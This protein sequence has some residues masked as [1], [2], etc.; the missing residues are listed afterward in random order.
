MPLLTRPSCWPSSFILEWIP[1]VYPM[2]PTHLIYWQAVR[3]SLGSKA[4]HFCTMYVSNFVPKLGRE[5]LMHCREDQML[6][7]SFSPHTRHTQRIPERRNTY[8]ITQRYF[9]L[10]GCSSPDDRNEWL[11]QIQIF[12]IFTN[13]SVQYWLILTFHPLLSFVELFIYFYFHE[14]FI[15]WSSIKAL[16]HSY[17]QMGISLFVRAL[18]WESYWMLPH[19]I[20]HYMKL[21]TIGEQN[22]SAMAE[23]LR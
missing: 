9:L 7:M 22:Q 12:S 15:S 8:I 6:S 18:T 17:L 21:E 1:E 11:P 16:I 13:H 10:N 2:T 5:L 4:T 20:R 23:G 19:V 3:H 14:L